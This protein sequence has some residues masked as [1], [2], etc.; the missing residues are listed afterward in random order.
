MTRPANPD[1]GSRAVSAFPV[2]LGPVVVLG[3][4]AWTLSI[5]FFPG[6]AI[7]QV[8]FARPYSLAT[9]LISDLDNTGCGPD[10]CSPLHTFMNATFVLVGALHV[11]GA[12]ATY[13]SWPRGRLRD[14]GVVLVTVAGTA[15][16]VAGLAPEGVAPAAHATAAL[17]GL[18]SLNLALITLGVSIVAARRWLG[19]ATLLVGI[20]GLVSLGQFLSGDGA[21]PVGVAERLADEPG[22]A[23]IVVLGV[24]ILAAGIA[25]RRRPAAGAG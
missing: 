20:V 8:A 16:I 2:S 12:L 4:V 1:A 9:N 22:A 3:G 14:I 15:L 17:V 5:V 24:C 7:A 11:L 21:I 18:I 25:H 23:M 19:R 10:I 6:Q 13:R